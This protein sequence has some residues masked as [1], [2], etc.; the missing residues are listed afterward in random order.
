[1]YYVKHFQQILL[2][3]NIFKKMLFC[4]ILHLQAIMFCQFGK[5]KSH[6][7]P[8]VK[9]AYWVDIPRDKFL[10]K[11]LLSIRVLFSRA[12]LN[13]DDEKERCLGK[14]L[15]MNLIPGDGQEIIVEVYFSCVAL[16][17]KSFSFYDFYKL[18]NLCGQIS[19]ITSTLT[20][21]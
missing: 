18:T 15:E 10:Y 8:L 13:K 6:K 21:I 5:I 9:S 3:S 12:L 14:N 19:R 11:S 20:N 1:M 16:P 4:K 17:L 7:M 2:Y